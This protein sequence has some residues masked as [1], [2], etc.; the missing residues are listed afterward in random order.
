MK[1]LVWASY[2]GATIV[3]WVLASG[4]A[5][6]GHIYGNGDCWSGGPKMCRN[7]WQQGQLLRV[8][9][10]DQFSTAHSEWYTA[11]NNARAN[12][13]SAA[14]PQVLSWSAQTNDTWDYLKWCTSG[15]PPC[16]TDMTGA[17][18]GLTYNCPV[19][20]GSCKDTGVA[21][22]VWYSNLYFNEI[23]FAGKSLGWRTHVFAHEIGHSLGL[24]HHNGAYLMNPSPQPS[25]T[26]PTSTDIG[27]LPPC[28]LVHQGIRCI[29]NW[30][31]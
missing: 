21:M 8:R 7:V 5:T 16:V 25:I 2:L 6:A 22:N 28:V 31:N 10:I 18:A 4:Q 29:Y 26:A 11:A 13:S 1:N 9:V 17:T 12:W 23:Q 27:A 14:G 3:L 24:S 30:N 20:G 19:G 15:P